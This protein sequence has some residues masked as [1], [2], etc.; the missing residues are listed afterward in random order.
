MCYRIPTM[1]T[2]GIVQ[3]HHPNADGP[4]N[5]T[6]FFTPDENCTLID[7]IA[8]GEHPDVDVYEEHGGGENHMGNT[9]MLSYAEACKRG[10]EYYTLPKSKRLGRMVEGLC[11][12]EGNLHAVLQLYHENPRVR[13]II[14][15]INNGEKY[16]LSI[17]VDAEKLPGGRLRN[18]RFSH[19]GLTKLPE[20]GG[21]PALT[22]DPKE[23]HLFGTWLHHGTVS[24]EGM[25][26]ILADKYLTLPGMY[27]AQKTRDRLAA[28]LSPGANVSVGASRPRIDSPS[29][30][31]PDP[32][33]PSVVPSAQSPPRMA[34]TTTSTIPGFPLTT[35]VSDLP[36]YEPQQQQQAAER[37]RR[38]ELELDAM[39]TREREMI[40][41]LETS[42]P[43]KFVRAKEL[44]LA[45]QNL[46]QEANVFSNPS[47][48]TKYSSTLFKLDDYV[49]KA[50]Q[51]YDAHIDQSGMSE[52]DRNVIKAMLREPDVTKYGAVLAQVGASEKAF[53]NFRQAETQLQK[54]KDDRLRLEDEIKK[55]DDELATYKKRDRDFEESNNLTAKRQSFANTALAPNSYSSAPAPAAKQAE[56]ATPTSVGATR[57]MGSTI[58]R[59]E[60]RPVETPYNDLIPRRNDFQ[61]SSASR[62]LFSDDL[63]RILENVSALSQKYQGSSYT[64]VDGTV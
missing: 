61:N 9:S 60:H 6:F 41:K 63:Q 17:G 11:D 45:F 47:K 33:N 56:G 40:D 7:T 58:P 54:E 51:A 62:T 32:P 50:E 43:S 37:L 36:R 31:T 55:R 35:P 39:Y 64:P 16:G 34:E 46:M 59:S 44:Q 1:Y 5:E 21:N 28:R 22:Y 12:V 8:S 2:I 15:G 42:D 25:D 13:E 4:A 23:P 3:G 29:L 49:L 26:R 18:K 38:A 57:N 52:T 30:I 48:R 53:H 14:K 27:A 10:T 20:Y 19:V 24:Y